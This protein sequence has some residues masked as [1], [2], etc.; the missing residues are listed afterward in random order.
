M[1]VD[2]NNGKLMGEVT[3]INGAH[4]V[5]AV[6][7]TGHGF[8]TSGNDSSVVMFDLKTYKVLGFVPAA[9]TLQLG[10]RLL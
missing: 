9:E 5:A 7:R 6:S 2:E 10:K 1:V 3:G 4:G 8:A